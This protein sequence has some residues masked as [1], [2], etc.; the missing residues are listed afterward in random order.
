MPQHPLV[1]VTRQLMHPSRRDACV[2]RPEGPSRILWLVVLLHATWGAVVTFWAILVPRRWDAVLLLT[3]VCIVLHWI[4][5]R[6]ECIVSVLEKHLMYV[7]YRMGDAPLRQ[8]YCDMFSERTATVIS[9][10]AMTGMCCGVNTVLWR[11][12]SATPH[13]IS[14]DIVWPPGTEQR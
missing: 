12:V 9:V 14:L 5:F 7:D 8:W 3:I 11:N 10:L 13:S 1:V 4:V 2:V 6:G